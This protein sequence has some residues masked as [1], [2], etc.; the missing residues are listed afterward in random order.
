MNKK[1]LYKY[2]KGKC[3]ESETQ[4][5]LQWYANVNADKELN[6]EIDEVFNAKS[7]SYTWDKKNI[8]KDILIQIEDKEANLTE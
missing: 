1:L 4:Q 3:T 8:L 2:F 5:V 6:Q 7:N